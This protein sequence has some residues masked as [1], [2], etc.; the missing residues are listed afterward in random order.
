MSCSKHNFKC[1]YCSFTGQGGGVS[2]LK[3][4]L[5]GGRLA[6][7]HDERI[8][9][10]RERDEDIEDEV[11]MHA[12]Y[13]L[14]HDVQE[15]RARAHSRAEAWEADQRAAN[16]V[17][18]QGA[19]HEVGSGSGSGSGM[20][21][22]R[23][24]IGGFAEP[25]AIA[26]RERVEGERREYEL[27]EEADDPED[28]PRPNTF[29]VRAVAEVTTEEE[30]DH[31]DVGQPY[32]SQRQADPEAEVD[33]LGDI[34]LE[35]VER[36]IGGGHGHD[37]DDFER[38]MEGL[39]CT[40]SRKT[41]SSTHVAAPS[42]SRRPPT[43]SQLVKGKQI[44]Q[45]SRPKKTGTTEFR[46]TKG[47]VIGEPPPPVQKKKGWLSGW[48]SKKGKKSATLVEDPLD[49]ADVETLDP[50]AEDDIPSP[51][52]SPW[53]PN[54][55]SHDSMTTGGSSSDGGGGGGGGG[56]TPQGGGGGES[57]DSG[58]GGG[59]GEIAFTEEQYF[60]GATQDTSH[61]A[62]LQY[63]RMQKFSRGGHAGGSTVDSNSYNTMISNFER[64]STQE[65][66]RSH[67]GHSYHPESID[68][69]YSSGYSV[70]TATG[71]VGGILGSGDERDGRFSVTSAYRTIA[72][73]G[74]GHVSSNYIWD[75][76]SP[77]KVKVLVW[78]ISLGI[79]TTEYYN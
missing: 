16:R 78:R 26:G 18:F 56:D 15:R 65:S 43:S 35:R 2:Q 75:T 17:S 64:T 14:D 71:Y 9:S 72:D 7:Y 23:E 21:S 63:N 55:A 22:F 20:K 12:E 58:Q 5:A 50:N 53:L 10:G 40:H 77:L 29:L 38:L 74:V 37:D 76:K 41:G 1:N 25:S 6:G 66:V 19:Q 30:G 24:A 47:I 67:G 11:E 69:D 27:D 39:P 48:G 61:S 44:A 52:D 45:E 42:Q 59:G 3:K 68:T 51:L 34:E 31:G 13:V 28:L 32:S 79:F 49:I 54:S 33:L 36:T 70:Y 57:G 46:P 60:R 73:G 8:I 62:S 4:H